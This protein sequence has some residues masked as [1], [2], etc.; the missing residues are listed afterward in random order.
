MIQRGW[1]WTEREGGGHKVGL[2]M[3]LG[4]GQTFSKRESPG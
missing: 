2:G 4:G 3:G 1:N